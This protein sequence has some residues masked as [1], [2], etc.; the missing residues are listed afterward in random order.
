MGE[1][2][3]CGGSSGRRCV[4]VFVDETPTSRA[5]RRE[6]ALSDGVMSRAGSSRPTVGTKVLTRDYANVEQVHE[7]HIMQRGMQVDTAV[8]RDAWIC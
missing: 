2:Q 3:R 6:G 4:T 7:V 1:S 8:C 5:V